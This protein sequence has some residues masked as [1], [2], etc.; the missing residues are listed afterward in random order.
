MRTTDLYID[1]IM[2]G[3]SRLRLVAEYSKEKNIITIRDIEVKKEDRNLGHASL[4]MDIL[5]DIGSH[6]GVVAYTGS[7]SEEDINDPNDPDHKDRLVHFYQ[8]YGFTVDLSKRR[9]E[10]NSN[11]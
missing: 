8:K 2:F 6:I 10:R 3:F 5:L 11:S 4:V 7:L 1:L 9:I